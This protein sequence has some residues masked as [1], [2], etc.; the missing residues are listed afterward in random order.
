MCTNELE[1]GF[2]AHLGMK[3]D[4]RIGHLHEDAPTGDT[5][6]RIGFEAE[7]ITHRFVWADTF[8]Q[9]AVR[10]RHDQSIG[11]QFQDRPTLVCLCEHE[12]G[13]PAVPALH[14]EL[15]EED[16]DLSE[17]ED[18]LSSFGT[19]SWMVGWVFQTNRHLD[20]CSDIHICAS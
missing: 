7:G 15:D 8:G 18:V 12:P 5:G 9:H 6:G 3:H 20:A 1:H 16:Q 2:R 10:Q 11:A 13:T 19:A 4:E 17:I 14:A